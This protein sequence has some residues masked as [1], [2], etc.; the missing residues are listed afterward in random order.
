MLP[1][2]RIIFSWIAKLFKL[3]FSS[4]FRLAASREGKETEAAKSQGTLELEL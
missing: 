3:K 1:D 2:D 4:Y